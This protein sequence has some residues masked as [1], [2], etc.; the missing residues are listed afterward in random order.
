MPPEQAREV[1]ADLERARNF[2]FVLDGCMGEGT[3]NLH[4]L[5]L[6]TPPRTYGLV[7]PNW[8]IFATRMLSA[9][10]GVQRVMEA[11]GVT[12]AQLLLYKVK[13][14]KMPCYAPPIGSAAATAAIASIAA[15]VAAAAAAAAVAAADAAAAAVTKASAA[16]DRGE[17]SVTEN[18]TSTDMQ[19][20]S[21]SARSSVIAPNADANV[22][23]AAAAAAIAKATAASKQDKLATCTTRYL[24][25]FNTLLLAEL[26]NERSIDEVAAKYKLSS[27]GMLQKLL[28]SASTF[29]QTVVQF[30]NA[31]RWREIGSLLVTF[32]KQLGAGGVQAELLPLMS[33]RVLKGNVRT[34]RALYTAGMT[35]PSLLAAAREEDIAAAM[36]SAVPFE[37][38]KGSNAQ[39]KARKQA[40]QLNE[41]LCKARTIRSIAERVVW[42]QAEADFVEA[43][44]QMDAIENP[45]DGPRI[46]LRGAARGRGRG[47]R[48]GRGSR[49]GPSGGYN[50]KR[51]KTSNKNPWSYFK[52]K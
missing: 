11:I 46:Y 24:R 31:L 6:L 36:L 4:L 10:P 9:P 3:P 47:G 22:T 26:L 32:S 49:G 21:V 42:E 33:V 28:E 38:V 19:R 35:E 14:P 50:G 44:Q 45:G 1:H 7:W 2:G 20:L 29:S 39:Q 13:P 17:S 15:A 8:Q 25:F 52:H 51:R 41:L 27:P 23:V 16:T 43:E 34:A 37:K 48:S 12:E 40:Q 5:Y 30:C 18:A